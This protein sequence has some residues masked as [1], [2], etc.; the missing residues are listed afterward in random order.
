MSWPARPK[1]WKPRFL[2][3]L[4]APPVVPAPRRGRPRPGRAG[5]QGYPCALQSGL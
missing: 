4:G 5:D 3:A 2:A 1:T